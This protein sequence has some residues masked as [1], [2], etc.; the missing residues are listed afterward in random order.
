MEIDEDS[1]STS[2]G[3]E[4]EAEGRESNEEDNVVDAF[5]AVC[6]HLDD[7]NIKPSAE[8]LKIQKREPMASVPVRA[9][10]GAA[11]YDLFASEDMV[12]D[13]GGQALVPTGIAV[14]IPKGHYGQIK[15]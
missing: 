13:A 1:D 11:G 3:E 6:V 10:E 5:L 9:S 14:D 4:G 7:L 2:E 8:Q 15:P 12:V